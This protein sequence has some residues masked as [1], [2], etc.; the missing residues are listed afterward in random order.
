M[1]EI[2]PFR[3]LTYTLTATN[4]LGR[5]AAPPYDMIDTGMIDALYAHDPHNV[6]RIIQNKKQP[7]DTANMDR[8]LRA[9]ELFKQWE[10]DGTLHQDTQPSV[11]IYQQH[12]NITEGSRVVAH[13]RTG[14]VALVKL[15]DFDAGI[16]FPHEYTLTGPKADRFELMQATKSHT[17]LIFGIVPDSD[18]SFFSAISAAV[19]QECR[20]CFTDTF[21]VQHNLYQTDNAGDIAAI[22][23]AMANETILI[24]DGHHRYETALKYSQEHTDPRYGYIMINLVSMADPGL[25]IR[26][27]HRAIKKYPGTETISVLD[28]LS[29]YF[30]LSNLGTA[31]MHGV[32]SFLESGD[33]SAMLYVDAQTRTM[34]SVTLN[35]AGNA[36]LAHNPRGMSQQWNTLDVSKINSIVVNGILGL[37]LDGTTLHDV[38]DY[39]NDAT[40][41]LESVLTNVAGYH[42]VFFI[43]P[44]GIGTINNIVS[45]N[46][47]MPQKSTN[48]FPKCYSGLVFND[49]ELS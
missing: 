23:S 46:E 9:A 5:F 43:K 37:P 27:F 48:F 47:R 44:V 30:S 15:V 26:A 38:I 39:R 20:G 25:V 22:V 3:G 32:N 31:D 40:L 35:E 28:K 4:D 6:V 7:Q 49:M 14:V 45:G 1:A 13:T 18:R 19:P 2:I 10:N 42:G 8:H 41:A 33:S 12:F 21:G 24:A 36:F 16:V 29:S 34:F 11:Y 17:E